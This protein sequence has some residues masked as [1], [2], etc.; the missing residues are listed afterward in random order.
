M[1]TAFYN[2]DEGGS[3]LS[4]DTLGRATI[5]WTLGEEI[6]FGNAPTVREENCYAETESCLL[7][8]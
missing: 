6:L 2:K 8:I 4:G 5:G 1:Q 3:T 7:G